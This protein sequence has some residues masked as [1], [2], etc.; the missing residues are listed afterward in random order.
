MQKKN[1]SYLT[2]KEYKSLF[3][4]LYTSLCLFSNK[5]IEDIEVSKDIV[6]DIFVKIW[7]H[8]I[9]FKD[10]NNIKS[11]LYTSVR[12]KSLDYLKSKRYK[13]TSHLSTKELEHIE[14]ETFFLRE[15]VVSESSIII[16]NAIN[17]LPGKCAQIIRMS[18]KELSNAEIANELSLSINTI[19]A[20]KKIAYK[21]L[22]PI[23]KEYY[24]L[25]AFIFIE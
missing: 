5:Y 11:Y 7:E 2:L 1:S 17:T 12:N 16:E 24:F 8:K 15:V 18:I 21:R 4:K 20:Q 13:N 10:K 9:L 14:T 23:L 25:I 3:D 19:K 22:K 6:Q